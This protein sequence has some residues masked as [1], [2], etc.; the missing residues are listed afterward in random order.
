MN[1][2]LYIILTIKDV[3][4]PY[5]DH[6]TDL[7]KEWDFY[8]LSFSEKNINTAFLF[9]ND[10]G[11]DLP[12]DEEELT[13]IKEI[14]EEHSEIYVAFHESHKK[15]LRARQVSEEC[16]SINFKHATVHHD[17]TPPSITRELGDIINAFYNEDQSVLEEKLKKLKRSEIWKL[18]VDEKDLVLQLLAKLS[19]PP[20][21]PEEYVNMGSQLPSSMQKKWANFVDEMPWKYHND[22]VNPKYI[23]HEGIL[24]KLRKA[25]INE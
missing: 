25:L 14:L 8:Y 18:A 10:A 16:S 9:I 24:T 4:T 21:N 19:I 1:S 6:F 20:H 7:K 17:F 22:F 5:F 15:Y 23:G 2:T 11:P 13:I 12:L 3:S